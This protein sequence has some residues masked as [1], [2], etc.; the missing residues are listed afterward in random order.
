MRVHIINTHTGENPLFVGGLN[1]YLCELGLSPR[2]IGGYSRVD[3]LGMK[4]DRVILTGVPLDVD[5]S[6]SRADTRRTVEAHFRW[7]KR[8]PCPVLGICYGCQII[9]HVLGGRVEKM[10]APVQQDG[11]PLKLATGVGKG[12]FGGI[13]TMSVFAEHSDYVS[14]APPGFLVLARK[15]DVKYILYHPE[16]EMYGVQFVPEFSGE[17]GR[18]MLRRFLEGDPVEV[19]G[20]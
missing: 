18:L 10:D 9:A 13:R 15:G 11:F 19:D 8:C 4:P 2:I 17:A 3:P 16:R 7:L 6:L 20:M 12:I 5:Y 1:G 14:E